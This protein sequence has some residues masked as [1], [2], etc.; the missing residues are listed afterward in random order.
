MGKKGGS[1]SQGR[2][3]AVIAHLPLDRYACCAVPWMLCD[4]QG[5][6]VAA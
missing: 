6:P 1:A 4:V 3:M 5:R 2:R